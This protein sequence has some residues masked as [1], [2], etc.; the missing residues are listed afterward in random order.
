MNFGKTGVALIVV[1]Y[2][3]MGNRRTR[4]VDGGVMAGRN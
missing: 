2:S 4:G 1:G 3:A